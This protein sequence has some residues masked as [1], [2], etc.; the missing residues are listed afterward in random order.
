MKRFILLL[1]V[2]ITTATC[3]KAQTGVETGTPY[4]RGEDSTRCAQNLTLFGV[5][6]KSNN[7]KEAYPYWKSAYEECPASSINIYLIGVNIIKWLI[8]E[9]PDPAK[10][11]ALIDDLMKIYDDRF[12][13]FGND[14]RV[15]K[16]EVIARKAYDYNSLKADNTDY[17]LMY[18]WLK[19]VIEETKEKTYPLAVSRYLFASMKLMQTDTE[20]YKEQ[21]INDFLM[22]SDIFDAQYSEAATDSVKETLS[23]L[24]SDMEK[25][26]FSSGVAECNIIEDIYTPKVEANKE[27]LAFLK[28]TM[29]LFS[30]LNCN[31]TDLFI[32]VSEYAHKIE[33]TAESATG[34]GLKAVKN[35]DYTTA[36]KY[37]L[38][39]IGMSDDSNSKAI[40]HYSI[41]A[42]A[43]QQEQYQKAR[44]FSLS[45]LKENP[46]YGRAYIL[47]ARAYASGARNIYPSDPSPTKVKNKL[48]YYLIVDKLE[49]ARQ[50]DPSVSKEATELINQYTK[51][52]PST[53][54]IFM[55]NEL[56][57]GESITIEGWVNETTKIREN[58]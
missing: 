14:P 49:R 21:Y 7:Y 12:K 25:M 29:K 9:E 23:G 30:R 32:T 36:E 6:A 58:K 31:E 55:H 47:I 46:N 17:N 56:K 3:V 5:H 38:E 54:E 50:V 41:A 4:G 10:K 34:L 2:C 35:K 16:D 15:R 18:T 48:I 53:E 51:Y 42:M 13:Y 40:L 57:E 26:F 8:S 20:K 22:C 52:F 45:C 33:P 19:E 37:Y 44:Q 1:A 43:L 11:E 27:N 39:A 28:E 24:K